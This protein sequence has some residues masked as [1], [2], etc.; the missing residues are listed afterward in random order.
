MASASWVYSLYSSVFAIV[1]SIRAAEHL[2]GISHW[3]LVLVLQTYCNGIILSRS[4]SVLAQCHPL[5]Q[6]AAGSEAAAVG[7]YK[8]WLLYMHKGQGRLP[9]DRNMPGDRQ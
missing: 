7:S 6:L 8:S 3:M 5:A 9:G 2:D 4:V 1:H